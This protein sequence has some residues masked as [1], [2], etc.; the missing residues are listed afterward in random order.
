M[1]AIL[2]LFYFC[3]HLSDQIDDLHDKVDQMEQLLR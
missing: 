1:K 3:S 2:E